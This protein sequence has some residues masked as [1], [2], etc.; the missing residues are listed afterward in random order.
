LSSS[1]SL[2]SFSVRFSSRRKR[3][4][5]GGGKREHQGLVAVAERRAVVV[6]VRADEWE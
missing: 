3:R 4:G 2:T 5:V 1:S 6:D